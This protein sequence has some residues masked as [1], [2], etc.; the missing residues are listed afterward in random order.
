MK[1][2]SNLNCPDSNYFW[3]ASGASRR[4]DGEMRY[5]FIQYN[6]TVVCG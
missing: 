6:R 2:F 1:D 3:L 4:V 5:P